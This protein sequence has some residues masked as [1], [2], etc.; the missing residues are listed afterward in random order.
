MGHVGRYDR[1]G[2]PEA[3]TRQL[4]PG[5]AVGAAADGLE[6]ALVA[7]IAEFYVEG[8]STA[9]GWSSANRKSASAV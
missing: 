7:V 5:L 9:A 4:L 6:Q 1:A 2:G 3:A 8:V